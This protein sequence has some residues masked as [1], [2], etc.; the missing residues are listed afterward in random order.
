MEWVSLML[1]GNTRFDNEQ[2]W[3][4]VQEGLSAFR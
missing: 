2:V 3:I 4:V 1:F